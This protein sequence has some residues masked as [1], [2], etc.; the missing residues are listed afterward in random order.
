MEGKP[1]WVRPENYQ[2]KG[3]DG[4][5]TRKGGLGTLLASSLQI[6]RQTNSQEAGEWEQDQQEG[7]WKWPPD[8]FGTE[9]QWE[10]ARG[11]G[12]PRRESWKVVLS[13]TQGVLQ[14]ALKQEEFRQAKG[15]SHGCF[16][17]GWTEK[18][19][20][21][22]VESYNS[23]EKRL[24]V[25]Q[26]LLSAPETS[27]H[28]SPTRVC[29]SKGFRCLQTFLESPVSVPKYFSSSYLLCISSPKGWAAARFHPLSQ[30]SCTICIHVT[31]ILLTKSTLCWKIE[32]T[33]HW[34]DR[35]HDLL[36]CCRMN[37]VLSA[38]SIAPMITS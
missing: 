25:W 29:F 12:S 36:M 27:Q 24:W 19:C 26:W 1:G 11:R 9:S 38:S 7:P 18:L 23:L 3:R 15:Q 13:W 17:L 4:V 14:Q 31:L 37:S 30:R 33:W 35:K 32:F 10:P 20:L 2:E 21:P 16:S 5:R 8:R 22:M 28:P 6:G 34:L